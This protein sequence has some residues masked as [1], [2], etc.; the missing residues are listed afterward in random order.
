LSERFF[1]LGFLVFLAYTRLAS[2]TFVWSF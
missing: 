2:L 1:L